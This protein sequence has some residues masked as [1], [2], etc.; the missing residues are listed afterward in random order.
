MRDRAHDRARLTRRRR[1]A[2][3]STECAGSLTTWSCAG[4]RRSR[5][6]PC[7]VVQRGA[8]SC[9]R[10]QPKSRM[11]KT[12]PFRGRRNPR[13]SAAHAQ[14]RGAPLPEGVAQGA[15]AT[16]AGSGDRVDRGRSPTTCRN[17]PK[18]AIAPSV[19]NEPIFQFA[20]VTAWVVEAHTALV[21]QD[22]AE[23]VPESAI[24]GR[25]GV[26]ACGRTTMSRHVAVCRG[27]PD[28]I[29]V[30]RASTRRS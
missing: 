11:R 28:G 6:P 24:G 13:S 4:A 16:G 10:M 8:T 7:N 1:R 2:W 27:T 30:R 14:K 12:N 25:A 20:F 22:D 18:C 17:V 5:A 29:L 21:A 9:N 23:G 3:R 15:S 19:Q 26:D